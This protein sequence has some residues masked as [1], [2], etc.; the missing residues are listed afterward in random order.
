MIYSYQDIGHVHL[1]ISSE[2][3]AECPRCPRNFN[4]YPLNNG[5]TEYSMSLT[6]AR[7]I[8]TPDFLRQLNEIFINGNFGDIVM[9]AEAAEIIEYFRS[10]NREL[11]IIIS[12][13][14]AARNQKFWKRL[15]QS[16]CIVEFCIDGLAD[17][18][19]I[20]RRNTLYDVVIRNAR[21]FIEAGGMAKWKFIVFDH[22][23]H[24]VEQA[25]MLADAMGFRRFIA[26]TRNRDQGPIFDRDK[27]MIFFMG[28]QSSPV[29]DFDQLLEQAAKPQSLDFLPQPA[30]RTITCQVQRDRSIYITS[31]GEVYPC[32]WLGHSP[33]SFDKIR[34]WNAS[35][36]QIAALV[37]ENNAKEHGIEH[38]MAWFNK[39]SASWQEND[40]RSGLLYQCM[41]TCGR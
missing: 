33:E 28:S 19:S 37:A 29:I 41:A 11:R 40:Y 2:C 7:Q 10:H 35:N 15:A 23:R 34:P 14:G 27:K 5:F 4:G 38:A 18:H 6:D 16:G 13:N 21:A 31:T 12:T 25:R 39:V 1:E 36:K 9:C 26:I 32:C 20:Y 30:G 22:N 8:F 3:N 17:T 24:Q